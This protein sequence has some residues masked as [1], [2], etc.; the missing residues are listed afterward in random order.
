MFALS[1]LPVNCLLPPTLHLYLILPHCFG[2]FHANVNS[3]C[4]H[5]KCWF[6]PVNL[7]CHLN[8]LTKLEELKGL[9]EMSPA[10]TLYIMGW[11]VLFGYAGLAHII[12]PRAT[13]FS[14][15]PP[16]IIFICFIC[17]DLSAQSSLEFLRWNHA[18]RFTMCFLSEYLLHVLIAYLFVITVV[19]PQMS[20]FSCDIV[21]YNKNMYLIIVPIPG[22][23]L[24]KP[25]EFLYQEQ[26]NVF[27]QVGEQW[28]TYSQSKPKWQTGL[29]NG[30]RRQRRGR[31]SPAGPSP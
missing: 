5:I 26:S 19:M 22:A 28:R 10:L 14:T 17:S 27:F 3:L 24:W 11:A 12:H 18:P 9:R 30:V 29:V 13:L 15:F 31:A 25:L 7:L 21:I 6:S 2:D 8:Y 16:L 1:P 20:I 4:T 23:E